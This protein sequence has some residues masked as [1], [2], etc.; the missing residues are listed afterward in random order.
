[1][2][3]SRKELMSGVAVVAFL[4]AVSAQSADRASKVV[5]RISG[6]CLETYS[7]LP[8]LRTGM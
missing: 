5:A 6:D 3:T 4:F 1:M 7:S 8:A 2:R